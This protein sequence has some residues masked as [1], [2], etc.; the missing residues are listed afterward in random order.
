MP[1][2]KPNRLRGVAWRGRGRRGAA[3]AELRPAHAPPVPKAI[4]ARLRIACTATCGSSAQAWTHRSPSLRAGS[5]SSPGKCGSRAQG[6][7]AAGRRG[8]TGPCPSASRNSDGPEAEG[9]R[10]AGRRQAER[11]AGVVGRRVVRAAGGART[12]RRPALGHPR[13]RRGPVAGAARPARRARRSVTS[14]AAKCSRSWAGVT[15]PAWCAPWKG[16]ARLRRPR[17][18]GAVRRPRQRAPRRPRRPRPRPD[19]GGAEQPAPGDAG[20]TPLRPLGRAGRQGSARARSGSGHALRRTAAAVSLDSG[21]DRALTASESCLDLGLASGRR[22][23]RTVAV[24][25][26]VEQRLQRGE[27]RR[28]AAR[29][30][31]GPCCSSSGLEPLEADR[32]PSTLAWK[33]HRSVCDQNSS[34]PVTLPVGDLVEQAL[35]AVA[36]LV[37]GEGQRRGPGRR[38]SAVFGE[39][40]VGVRRPLRRRSAAV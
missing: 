27:P 37:D 9:D 4:R 36:D 5:R 12:A 33:S 34:S 14:K 25:V 16:Y 10:Q 1:S 40:V 2:L 26:L 6:R 29:R 23:S 17:P 19:A 13:G 8:R 39:Q 7:R 35:G 32:A 31:R 20:G 30:A 3:E 15:M 28:R 22:R 21:S 18:A 11:L 38:A 24:L